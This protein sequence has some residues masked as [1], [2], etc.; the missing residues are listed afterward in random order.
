MPMFVHGLD[1]GLI[2]EAVVI[3][4]EP[5]DLVTGLRVV[6]CFVDDAVAVGAAVL[7]VAAASG[8]VLLAAAIWAAPVRAFGRLQRAV[9]VGV[10]LREARVARGHE[11]GAAD[12]AVMIAVG[13]RQPMLV[14]AAVG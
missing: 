12:F 10:H 1:F 8:S 6:L 14:A 4:V 9:V 13:I 7:A 11:L 5:V 2:Q 3:G